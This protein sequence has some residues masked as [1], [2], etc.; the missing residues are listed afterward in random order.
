MYGGGGCVYV[1][2]VE[3]GGERNRAIT[4]IHNYYKCKNQIIVNVCTIST[5]PLSI[6][7]GT[8]SN[9]SFTSS[10]LAALIQMC[11]SVGTFSRA[12]FNTYALDST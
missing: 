5:A 4:T 6:I 2:Y 1:Q 11:L 8:M 7:L 9:F 10:S 12:L 3:E